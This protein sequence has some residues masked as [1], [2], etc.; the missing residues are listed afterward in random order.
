MSDEQ[1]LVAPM[2][3][4]R[5]GH[6]THTG[7]RWRGGGR[8]RGQRLAPYLLIL[9]AV[10]LYAGFTVV[11]VIYT[12]VSSVFAQRLSG[13]SILGTKKSVF[14]GLENYVDVLREGQ[15]LSGV[16]RVLLYGIIAVP[17]TLGLAL[18]FA[19]LLD[20]P[21]ARARRFSRT[22]IFVPYAVPGVV[23]A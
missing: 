23:G 15:L 22:A 2:V 16:G 21:G 18:L 6:A 17:L 1:T 9:P 7:V 5:P 8:L 4:R 3:T 11:P 12:L 14:V 19:L 10:L 20:T 13:G